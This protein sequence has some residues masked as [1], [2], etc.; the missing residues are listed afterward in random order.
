MKYRLGLDLGIGSIGSAITEIDENNNAR[1]IIDAGSRIFEVSEGAEDR[2]VKRTARKNLIRTRKRLELL[3][4]KLFENNLWVNE[5]SEGTRKLKAI[6]PY[7]IRYNAIYEKL[8]NPHL[9]GRAL[10]HLGKHRGAGFVSAGEEIEEQILE[11]EDK[12]KDKKLSS[13]EMMQKHLNDTHSKT[14]GEFFYK[15]IQDSYKENADKNLRTVRQKKYALEAKIVD[16]AIPRYLVKDEFSQIWDKQ[17]EFYPQMQNSNL[18]KEI[19]NILFYERPAA[20][21]ATADCIYI[22]G[23]KRLSKAHPLSEKRRIYEEVNNIR[24]ITNDMGRQPLTLEQRDKIINELLMKGLN[25]GKKAIK[26]TL[27]LSGQ[28]SLSLLD[29]KIIKAYL[30]SKPEFTNIDYFNMLSEEELSD[31]IEFLAEPKNPNDKN[32]R[33]YNEDDLIEHL[34]IKLKINDE[35]QIGKLLTLLPKSRGMLGK[36][37]ATLLLEKMKERVITH[38][39]ASDELAKTDP[40]FTAEEEIARQLQ[41]KL[42]KLPYYGKILTKD[43]QPIPELI[44][45]YG[46]LNED[47]K[48]YG[49]IANPA[50]HMILNQLRLVVNDIIR[51]Y[52]KP[53]EIN[54]ELGRDVGLSTKKKKELE[55]QQKAN[56][57]LNNEAKEYLTKHKLYLNKTNILKYKLAKEQGWIDAYNPKQNIPHRFDG[58]EIE[59][60]IPQAKGGTDTYNNLCL[61]NRNDNLAK[62]NDFAYEYFEKSKNEEEIREILKNARSYTPNKVWRFEPEAKEQFEEAGDE[63]ATDRRLTDTRYVSKMSA[64]YLRAILD[65]QQNSDENLINTRILTIKGGQTAHLRT[66]WNLDGIEYDLMGLDVPR[67]IPCVPYWVE[68]NT[69]EVIEQS[70]KPDID[71]NWKYYDKKKNPEWLK[72]PRIDH[73]HHAM[74][75]IIITCLNRSFLQKLG[76]AEN[77]GYHI[78]KEEYPMPLL[79]CESLG[80]FRNEVIKLLKDVNV[81]HKPDHSKQGQFHEETGKVKLAVNPEDNEAII[82][83]YNRKILNVIKSKKDLSKLLIPSSIKD[84][85]HKNITN[86]K[87]AQ[88]E[89]KDNFEKYFDIAEQTL[90]AKNEQDFS[91][92][93]KT[94]TITENMILN[95][96]FRIIQKECLWTGNKFKCYENS[97]SLIDIEK[98]GVAYKSGNNHC[99]DFYEQGGKVGWEVI[100]RFNINQINFIPDSK[101][102]EAKIIWSIQQGDLIELDVPEEWKHYTNKT[103]CLAKIKKFS[104]GSIT[105]DYMSDARMTSPKDKNLKY[106][107][108]DSLVN[109]GLSFFIKNSARKIELTPFGKIKRKHKALWNGKKTQA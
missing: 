34:K 101:Q 13:Y 104:D 66:V 44:K 105:I 92:G 24:I 103:K 84:E 8:E 65:Y 97:K 50:V 59:H 18:K 3:A 51:I 38:R 12:K 54:L 98:H 37:A 71:G 86:D 4:K 85:W 16:F 81:S 42:D 10:L 14:I 83:V 95:E 25:A 28:Q 53:Y 48:K 58:F 74:D 17:A 22:K 109:R 23:E 77:K 82:T 47:E 100:S 73:R 49:K 75:A 5:L 9:I 52:G 46:S 79:N 72:K 108:V 55:K 43:T 41:G 102:N 94:K 19:Y 60:I 1:K 64:R 31:F 7:E 80:Q 40:R 87:Q 106:M 62:G 45:K 32:G 57:K 20:P 90:I 76:H 33:L 15:R 99:V 70:V 67:Y 2:R 61:V 30:Y 56:E 89:L 11:D 63:E 21:Y 35:K 88:S 27:G 29:D 93:K 107:F 6:S 69:G 39:E 78:K 36:T 91:E 26:K 68:Q 96:T